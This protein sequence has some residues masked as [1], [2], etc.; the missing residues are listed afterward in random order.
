MTPDELLTYSDSGDCWPPDA[1]A[2]FAD[3]P[4]AYQAAL[5]VRALRVA[6]GEVPRGYKVGFTNRGIWPRY[7]VFAPIWGS[8][9]DTTVSGCDDGGTLSV[10]RLCQP[11]IEPEAVFGFRSTPP[12]DAGIE[13]LFAA[14]DW[15]APGFELVQSHRPDWKFVAA[16]TVAD[17][18]L[19]ARLLVGRR[20]PIESLARDAEGLH[21]VLA[22]ARVRLLQD[23]KV[24]E[25]GAGAN[26]L[27]SPLHAL[28]HFLAELRAC[29]GA[30][31]IAEG[32]IVTTGTWTDAWPVRAGQRWTARFDAALPA[33][34][35]ALS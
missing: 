19:H 2:G 17:G 31:D 7:N 14:L 3:L 16:Q 20:V 35:L 1:G 33:L 18:G 5:A 9:W 22:G 26:V 13:D 25:E 6:R 4:S 34:E 29:P 10:D 11:R 30:P 27:D 15:V 28:L 23:G 12:V 21:R 8:M 32:D 24:V